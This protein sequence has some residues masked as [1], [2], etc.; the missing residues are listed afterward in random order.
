MRRFSKEKLSC[1]G[2]RGAGVG[3]RVFLFVLLWQIVFLISASVVLAQSQSPSGAKGAEFT[4]IQDLNPDSKPLNRP[5]RQKWAVVIGISKFRDRR[6]N[7]DQAQDKAAIRFSEY[8]VNPNGGRFRTDHVRLLTNDEASQQS[9]NNSFDASWLGKLAGP[10]DLVVVYIATKAFPTTDGNSYL[11]SYNC[12]MDNIFGTCMSIQTLMQ[13]LRKNIQSDRIVLILESPGSGA[14]ELTGAKSLETANYNVDL[15][16]V[17]LGKGFIILT[18]SR[19]DQLSWGSLFSENL[20]ASLKENDGQVPLQEAF[21]KARQKTEYD[22]VNKVYQGR[23]QTPVM[24]SDWKGNDLILGCVP[25]DQTTG[26]PDSA[27]NFMGAE[28]HYLKANRAVLASDFA[29]AFAEYKQ[30]IATDQGLTDARADYAVALGMQGKWQEAESE[31]RK[32]IA[33][34]PD[35]PLYLTNYARVLD[36]LGSKEECKRMLERAYLLNPKDRVVLIA[37]SDK[38]LATGDQRMA[39]QMA[40][41]ALVLYPNNAV[42][43]DRMAFLLS[44]QGRQDEAI[45][46]AKEAVKLDPELS[47]ARLKLGALHVLRGDLA[48]GIKEYQTVLSKNDANADAHYLLAG[49]LDK[50]NDRKGASNEYRKFLQLASPSDSRR[51][52]V[53]ERLRS[54]E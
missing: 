52:S 48:S 34:K 21:L 53:E 18:S 23:K 41:Q 36:K 45:V 1:A 17:S 43:Q 14:A 6:L 47:S 12:A 42:V 54:G 30:A 44:L 29:T 25:L 49:A 50:N 5:V 3:G 27:R 39:L 28:A 33:L 7:S 13:T 26:I 46:H 11:C 2:P 31:L 8:L 15:D 9:I 22:S 38:C 16:R 51:T 40:D 20:I 24:K 4:K 37:L 32:A 10:D 35:D 19:P